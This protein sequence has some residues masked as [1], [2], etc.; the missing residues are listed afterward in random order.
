M[1]PLPKAHRLAA[2]RA[3]H[4]DQRATFIAM[5]LSMDCVRDYVVQAGAIHS[6]AAQFKRALRSCISRIFADGLWDASSRYDS[7]L[8]L[9]EL[10]KY[11]SPANVRRFV[12]WACWVVD[13]P[14]EREF[15]MWNDAIRR[16]LPDSRDWTPLGLRPALAS[17][18]QLQYAR[19]NRRSPMCAQE[20]SKWDQQLYRILEF[21]D[22]DPAIEDP[23]SFMYSATRNFQA[24]RFWSTFRHLSTDA[25]T[26]GFQK[27]VLTKLQE[28]PHNWR[29]SLRMPP[30]LPLINATI[31]YT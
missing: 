24:L 23:Y 26:L 18:L 16:V 8:F 15:R 4:F 19:Y 30:L 13:A 27:K 20:R 28:C 12:W 31:F 6:H 9:G 3:K 22:D 29:F 11:A 25:E 14:N 21:D 17:A 5:V 10:R 7:K 1:I 2:D